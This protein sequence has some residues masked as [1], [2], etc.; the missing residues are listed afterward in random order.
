MARTDSYGGKGA[1][2]LLADSTHRRPTAIICSSDAI[3]MVVQKVAALARL[4]LPQDLS[5]TGYSNAVLSSFADP[6]L[7]TVDQSFLDMGHAAATHLMQ[8]AQDDQNE[9][10][11]GLYPDILIP[12]RLIV[13]QSTTVSAIVMIG[14]GVICASS[15]RKREKPNFNQNRLF[16]R[17]NCLYYTVVKNWR[18]PD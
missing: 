15:T 5:I 11:D 14:Y 18:Q 7:T 3:A 4:R 1:R 2:F 10:G 17:G 13:R 9:E 6:S 8:C 12:T 16:V